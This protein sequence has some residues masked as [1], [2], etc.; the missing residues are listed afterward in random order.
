MSSMWWIPLWWCCSSEAV[1]IFAYRS[2]E[3]ATRAQLTRELTAIL[4]ADVEALR[5]WLEGERALVAGAVHDPA[6]AQHTLELRE[7]ERTARDRRDAL[8][9]SDAAAALHARLAPAVREHGLDNFTVLDP[10]G[11]VLVD[12]MRQLEGRVLPVPPK[13]WRR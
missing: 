5:I 12:G 7:L 2:I 10:D 13:L 11:L 9:A 8:L 3:D 1:G 4:E 6:I